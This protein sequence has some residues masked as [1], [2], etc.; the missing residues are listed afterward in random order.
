MT[1][2]ASKLLGVDLHD[3]ARCYYY[4]RDKVLNKPKLEKELVEDFKKELTPG[5]REDLW[6]GFKE[7]WTPDLQQEVLE[8]FISR[9]RRE[10]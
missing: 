8:E 5:L 7:E 10:M 6:L 2:A 1:R 4:L 3:T 9:H